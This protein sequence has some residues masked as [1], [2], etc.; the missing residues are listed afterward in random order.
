[1]GNGLNMMSSKLRQVLIGL[2]RETANEWVRTPEPYIAEVDFDALADY[3]I[4]LFA[5]SVKLAT[6]KERV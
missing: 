5:G 3:I 2:L 6:E 4:G 1:M